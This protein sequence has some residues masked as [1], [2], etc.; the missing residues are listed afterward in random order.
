MG[1]SVG[2]SVSQLEVLKC[3]PRLDCVSFHSFEDQ[4]LCVLTR[5]FNM[6]LVFYGEGGL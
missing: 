6:F 4:S 2:Q 1:R 3:E 5:R